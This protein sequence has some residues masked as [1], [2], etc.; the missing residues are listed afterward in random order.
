MTRLNTVISPE[1]MTVDPVF[2]YDPQLKDVSNVHDLSKMTGLFDCERDAALRVNLPSS[3]TGPAQSTA[4]AR[5]GRAIMQDTTEDN[6]S[7]MSAAAPGVDADDAVGP[8]TDWVALLVAGGAGGAAVLLLVG[9]VVF[10]GF[11]MRRSGS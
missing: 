5:V 1:E 2:D 7:P 10:V 11:G 4:Q 3:E 8:A 6:R 9:L